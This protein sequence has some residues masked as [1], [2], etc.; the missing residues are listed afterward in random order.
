VTKV[1]KFLPENKL[2]RTLLDPTGMLVGQAVKNA[3][4]NVEKV[5]DDYIEPLRQKMDELVR[6]G[7]AVMQSRSAEEASELYRLAREVMS[8]S[9]MLGLKAVSRAGHSLCELMSAGERHPHQWT[10]VAVHVE[11]MSVLRRDLQGSGPNVAAMLD[12]LE[13]ISRFALQK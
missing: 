8:D 11:A 5:R 10:G 7:L 13:K 9:G 6:V 12:G 1:R 2:S 3:A 4:K